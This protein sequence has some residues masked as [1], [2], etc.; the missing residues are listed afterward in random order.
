MPK[1]DL[2]VVKTLLLDREQWS[3]EKV[4][5]FDLFCRQIGKVI[6]PKDPQNPKEMIEDVH[7]LITQF[8]QREGACT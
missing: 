4:L 5:R 8:N 6:P 7:E 1:S 2:Q 3:P